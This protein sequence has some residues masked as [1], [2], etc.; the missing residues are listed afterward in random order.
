MGDYKAAVNQ[1][2]AIKLTN[3][4]GWALRRLPM[5]EQRARSR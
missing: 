4:F 3:D 1:L 5:M 2:K